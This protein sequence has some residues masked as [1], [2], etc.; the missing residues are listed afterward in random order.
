MA[1]Q[2][3]PEFE[4]IIKTDPQLHGGLRKLVL[5]IQ[6][7]ETAN[8]NLQDQVTVLQKKVNS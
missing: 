1:Q 2:Q 6:Q 4:H 3:Y 7:L 8:A 5:Q